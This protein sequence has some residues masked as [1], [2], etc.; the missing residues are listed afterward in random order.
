VNTINEP[1]EP[2]D[3]KTIRPIQCNE[4]WAAV[5]ARAFKDADWS[6][7]GKKATSV[8]P[9]LYQELFNARAYALSWLRGT[10]EGFDLICDAADASPGYVRRI[11][12]SRYGSLLDNNW[13]PI[14][15]S[16]ALRLSGAGSKR[17]K[18]ESRG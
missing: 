15:L 16:E 18:D 11:A 10:T 8:V 5:I 7:I 14:K 9:E 13:T 3:P 12:R 1:I 2:L 17:Q 4:L 6:P